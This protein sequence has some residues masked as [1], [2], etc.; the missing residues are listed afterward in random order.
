M[1]KQQGSYRRFTPGLQP[2]GLS[3]SDISKQIRQLLFRVGAFPIK[4]AGGPYQKPGISDW[5]V[6]FE[7]RFIAI[8]VKKPGGKLTEK[9]EQ[10]LHDVRAAGGIAFVAYSVDEVIENLGLSVKLNP[11]FTLQKERKIR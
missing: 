11:L 6:C 8:E 7:G 10:F 3:E 4:I 5:L 2:R 9:Q 1:I